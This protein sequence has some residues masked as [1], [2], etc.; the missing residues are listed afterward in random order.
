MLNSPIQYSTACPATGT[1]TNPVASLNPGQNFPVIFNGQNGPTFPNPSTFTVGGWI[2]RQTTTSAGTVFSVYGQLT[3]TMDAT[4]LITATLGNVPLASE[5]PIGDVLWHYVAVSYLP[6]PPT[7]P[8]ETGVLTLYIDGIEGAVDTVNVTT[9]GSG[10]GCYLGVNN[11]PIEFASWSIWSEALPSDVIGAPQWGDPTQGTTAADGLVAAYDFA[12]GGAKD[13]SS[14]NYPVTVAAQCWHTP[15]MQLNTG[16]VANVL[17][18]SN[19]NPGGGTGTPG[20]FSILGWACVPSPQATTN[21]QLFTNGDEGLMLQLTTDASNALS[22]GF[23]WSATY[24]TPVTAGEWVH[25]ALTWDGNNTLTFYLNGVVAN[26]QQV[27]PA[28]VTQDPFIGDQNGGGGWYM[29]GLSIWSTCLTQG[30]VDSYLLGADPT[31]QPGCVANFALL[32]NLGDSI[33][34]NTLNVYNNTCQITEFITPVTAAAAAAATDAPA[35]V[36]ADGPRLLNHQDLIAIAKKNGIDVDTPVSEADMA[37]PEYAEIGQWF[38]GLTA[39]LPA[40][41]AARLKNQF[42][43]HARIGRALREKGIQAGSY[44]MAVEGGDTVGYYHTEDGPQEVY[45]ATGAILSNTQQKALIVIFDVISL[46]AS[47]FGIVSSAAKV[48]KAAGILEPELGNLVTAI[49]N[50]YGITDAAL[51]KAQKVCMVVIGT[52]YSG[53]LLYTVV[54]E[55]V[56]GSWWSL[57]FTILNTVLM[58]GGL[59]ATSGALIAIRVAQMGVALGTLV[60]DLIALANAINPPS[61]QEAVAAGN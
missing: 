24:K 57:A 61:P 53:N 32:T 34:G 27:T 5:I 4:G 60:A 22:A 30:A 25:C 40:K 10:T 51:V 26:T 45:R 39:D 35:P 14:T 55:I 8:N 44:S 2:R 6:S 15:C 46:I 54:K 58:I 17:Q 37:G 48:T 36:A 3:L 59:V 9:P 31:D 47:M 20:P 38:D 28:A 16:G 18:A 13:L 33:N 52:M 11:A 19:V 7:E 42:L 23:F 50:S 1:S 21:Y 49:Q 29:Q 41:G 12:N 56:T 43:R